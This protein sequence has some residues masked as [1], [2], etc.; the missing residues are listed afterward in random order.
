MT[1]GAGAR[2]FAAPQSFSSDAIERDGQQLVVLK[3][4]DKN[5]IADEHGRGVTRRQRGFPEDGLLRTELGG[6]SAGFGD[7]RSLG[8]T[9]TRPVCGV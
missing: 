9:E 1:I 6:Q 2:D 7:T 4:R 5:A 8:S 3:C